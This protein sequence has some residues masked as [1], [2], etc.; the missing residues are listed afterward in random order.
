MR[1]DVHYV[2][3]LVGDLR[4]DPFDADRAELL[5]DWCEETGFDDAAS[6]LRGDRRALGYMQA[7]S[8][9]QNLFGYQGI[10]G[11]VAPRYDA[12]VSFERRIVEPLQI[13]QFEAVVFQPM[14]LRKLIVPACLANR[15]YLTRAQVGATPMLTSADPVDGEVFGPMMPDT[16]DQ[17]V[18]PREPILLEFENAAALPIEFSPCFLAM[19]HDPNAAPDWLTR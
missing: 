15:I 13:E 9:I 17:Q 1:R 10:S 11:G 5:A 12:V 8:A 4:R 2:R 18:R 7:L 14:K 6:R 19:L 16:F 3:E